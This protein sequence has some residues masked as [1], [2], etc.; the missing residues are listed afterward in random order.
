MSLGSTSSG[1]G[2]KSLSSG[3]SIKDLEKEKAGAGI[4]ASSQRP[5][6]AAPIGM[7]GAL[8]NNFGN[9]GPV[10][11]GGGSAA[12]GGDDLLL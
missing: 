8:G 11:P 10:K 5:A 3:K 6:T 4:W 1:P 7:G 2:D 9:F 12:A